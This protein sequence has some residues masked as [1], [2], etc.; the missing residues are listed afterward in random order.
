M[1]YNQFRIWVGRIFGIVLLFSAQNTFNSQIA[2]A[3]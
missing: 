3:S 1:D 2:S